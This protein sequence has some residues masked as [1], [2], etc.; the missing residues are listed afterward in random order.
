MELSGPD[1]ELKT[2]WQQF[3]IKHPTD[4]QSIQ[5]IDFSETF[6]IIYDTQGRKFSIDFINDFSNYHKKKS[7]IKTELISKA[8]GGGKKGL[9]LLDLSAGLGIDAI[10]LSQLGYTVTALERNSIIYLAL[11]TAWKKLPTESRKLIKFIYASAEDFLDQPTEDFDVCY[12]DP[13]FP[14]K[15]KSALPKQQMILFK[16]LVGSD[17]DAS[18]V[19]EKLLK[20]KKF[21]RLVVKRPLKADALFC[22]P[23]S[24]ISGKLIRFDIYGGLK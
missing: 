2:E 10:F 9:R 11:S 23:Q 16:Q 5:K 1:S 21:S 20:S 6:P 17:E 8:M 19:I 3:L 15:K 24:C 22:K 18:Q 12:F 7:S 4:V 13:M 14:D